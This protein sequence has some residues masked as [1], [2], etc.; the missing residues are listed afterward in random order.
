MGMKIY[1]ALFCLLC[2]SVAFAAD[3]VSFDA[4][5]GQLSGQGIEEKNGLIQHWND[6]KASVSWDLDFPESGKFHFFLE[7]SCQGG[8]DGSILQIRLD[9]KVVRETRLRKS[10]GRWAMLEVR[11]LTGSPLAVEA[12]KHRLSLHIAEQRRVGKEMLR[13]TR[14]V[15]SPLERA[16]YMEQL[17]PKHFKAGK[18]FAASMQKLHEHPP[19]HVT[20]NTFRTT[21][22]ELQA[23][24]PQQIC[25]FA[26]D[27]TDYEVT[28]RDRLFDY[29][30]C[31]KDWIR[32]GPTRALL[33]RVTEELPA[34]DRKALL[35]E[36]KPG[37]SCETFIA[38]YEKACRKRRLL[39]LQSLLKKTDEIIFAKHQIFA[40][41]SGIYNIT[42]TE[43]LHLGETSALCRIDLTSEKEGLFA[44]EILLKDA[45]NGILRDPELSFDGKRLLFAWRKTSK[46]TNSSY[47]SDT[48]NY[49][50]YEMDLATG[51][52]RQLTTD[53]TYGANYEPCYMPNGDIVFNSTRIVQHITCGFGDHANLF[54]M[55]KDGEY[56]R[57]VGF[58]QVSSQFPTVLNNGTVIYLRR[59]YNDRGQSAAHALFVMNP[60]GTGQ[61]EFYGNQTGTPNSFQHARAIPGSDKVACVLSGYH[62][63]QGGQLALID[64]RE[65]RNH[66]EG[67]TQIPQGTRPKSSTGYD[68]NYAKLGIQYAYPY[69]LSETE[70]IVSRSEQWGKVCRANLE[71]YGIYF[72]TTDGRRELL[73]YDPDNSCL[74]PIPVMERPAPPIRPSLT[75]YRKDTGVYYVQNV[76]LGA[77]AEGIKPGSVKQLRVIELLYKHAGVKSGE[78]RGPGGGTATITPPAHPLALFDAKRIIGT[79]SVYEDGSAMF[80]VPARTPVYFQLLDEKGRC[81][82]TMRSWS[83]LMPNER[84]SC[85]GCHEDKNDTPVVN[86]RTIA[87]TK[88]VEKLTPF[89]GPARG[90]SYLA[91]VQPVFDRHCISC[92]H[93]GGKADKLHLTAEPFVDSPEEGRRWAQSYVQ[94]MAARPGPKP[95]D[96][97]IMKGPESWKRRGRALPD[98]PNR[99]VQYWGRLGKMQFK[100]PYYAGA[101][102]S[103][104]TQKIDAGHKGVKLNREEWDK[105]VAWIDLNCPYT[106]DYMEANVWTDEQRI[107]YRGRIAERQRNESI[108]TNAIKAYINARRP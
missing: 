51:D 57:R 73:A 50:I 7:M 46:H 86:A 98:E 103:G 38:I 16:R 32:T 108:E 59:D 27:A 74:Q 65:G 11:R 64:I 1:T 8:Y 10:G 93:P 36:W 22:I 37:L 70:F 105:L 107:M 4:E 106:G 44:K 88:G 49:Q 82:Q 81:I 45:K 41:K 63:R 90:F 61:T 56:Q 39:R 68:D 30:V 15:F 18:T 77:A 67:I 20:Q 29:T 28:N 47:A 31:L 58:D 104:L 76:Y 52:T 91:E 53:E 85:V 97:W 87:M 78:D 26:Q 42:E 5:D 19:R 96:Y 80:E 2:C 72:M 66:G 34:Q 23:H 54:L 62:I 55:N 43:G 84:F 101:I 21:Y 79:A 99:Y 95:S 35:T 94:L 48:G 24:F 102:T 92:H 6:P 25:W 9:D 13:F 33:Q 17:D 75:D 60:D 12:G 69:P 40:S 71:L 3:G 89:Y 83:T 100:P 14:G